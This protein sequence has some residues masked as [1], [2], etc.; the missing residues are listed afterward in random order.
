MPSNAYMCLAC[1]RVYIILDIRDI[2]YSFNR[3]VAL[4]M[5]CLPTHTGVSD[6]TSPLCLV[7]LLCFAAA[8]PRPCGKGT[9]NDVCLYSLAPN[10]EACT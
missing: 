2:V 9:D 4:Y 3:A 10:T 6:L 7:S 5:S 1:I 8:V